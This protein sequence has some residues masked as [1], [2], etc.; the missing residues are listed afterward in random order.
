MSKVKAQFPSGNFYLR[1]GKDNNGVIHIRY[2]INGR[3]V[4][5]S[6]G[7]KIDPKTWDSKSQ[8]IKGSSNPRINTIANQKNLLLE[9][10]KCK[11]DKQIHQYEGLLTYEVLLLIVNGDLITKEK[12][13]KETDFI[14]YHIGKGCIQVCKGCFQGFGTRRIM[15]VVSQ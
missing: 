5:K 12:Q 13:I 6:T 14:S 3:Y 4:H 15:G 1:T 8:K 9:E 7:V 11:I 2:F 10:F